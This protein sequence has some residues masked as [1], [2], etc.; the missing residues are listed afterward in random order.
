MTSFNTPP[1]HT[2]LRP[3]ALTVA[4]AGALA[5]GACSR[6]DRVAADNQVDRGVAQMDQ[7]TDAIQA[8]ASRAYERAKDAGS[9]TAAKIGDKVGD[10]AITT[11]VNA[12][13]AK[14]T[15]LSAL[16]INVDTVDGRVVL[17]G[18]APSQEARERATRL[19]ANVDGVL[20]VENTLEVAAKM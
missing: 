13:L 10:A 8:D 5:L 15:D 20:A 18:Q 4:L 7:K 16:A 14:D 11:A 12:E 3:L 9:A 6:E 19:A 1:R 2:A 17:K